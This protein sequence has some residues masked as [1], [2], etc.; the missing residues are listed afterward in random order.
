MEKLTQHL[1]DEHD[2]AIALEEGKIQGIAY[3]DYNLVLEN[4][5]VITDG[6]RK[7]KNRDEDFYNTA[8]AIFFSENFTLLQILRDR[9]V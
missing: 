7:M 8:Y 1:T 6:L 5:D 4:A 2:C 3:W 9:S